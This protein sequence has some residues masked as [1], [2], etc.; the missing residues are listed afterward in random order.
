MAG[1]GLC[2]DFSAFSVGKTAVQN[3][4][5]FGL[6]R[7]LHLTARGFEEAGQSGSPQGGIPL[8]RPGRPVGNAAVRT[9]TGFAARHGVGQFHK[10][11][12]SPTTDL[13]GAMP[14]PNIRSSVLP[15]FQQVV[16]DE[17]IPLGDYCFNSGVGVR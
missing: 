1:S 17:V 6:L 4:F 12:A 8:P 9:R 2:V 13:V 16:G 10:C 7:V 5:R 14:L 11:P 3:R 15:P